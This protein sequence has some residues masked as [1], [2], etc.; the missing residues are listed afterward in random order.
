MAVSS[1]GANPKVRNFYLRTKGE[2]EEKLAGIGFGAASVQTVI[3]AGR[4]ARAA[5]WR[6]GG[7]GSHDFPRLCIQRSEAGS[8]SGHTRA[9]SSQVDGE[10]RLNGYERPPCIHQ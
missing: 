7:I 2:V 9:E 4:A 3:I 6:A 10:Y 8:I 5:V 1:A